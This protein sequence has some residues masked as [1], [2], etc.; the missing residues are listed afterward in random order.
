MRRQRRG[1][2]GR[3]AAAFLAALCLCL[4]DV[5]SRGAR[6]PRLA[7]GSH[8]ERPRAHHARAVLPAPPLALRGAGAAGDAAA[9][10]AAYDP[11]PDLTREEAAA[12][13]RELD[14]LR[15][16]ARGWEPRVLCRAR[17]ASRD[18]ARSCVVLRAS[19]ALKL[20]NWRADFPQ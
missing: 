7:G 10:D 20:S 13:E 17:L 8:R 15:W 5:A 14:K 6:A 11:A 19:T 9:G 3:G 16:D 2:G 1:W 4:F 18:D 12:L